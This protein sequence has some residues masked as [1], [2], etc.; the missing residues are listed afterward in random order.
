MIRKGEKLFK[1]N[2]KG[3]EFTDDQWIG[4]MVNNPILIERPIVIKGDQ[5]VIGRPPENIE[6]L[7]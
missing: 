2:F 7:Y 4:V 6:A 5:A 1:D 3:K